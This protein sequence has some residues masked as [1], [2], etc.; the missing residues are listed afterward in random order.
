MCHIWKNYKNW[1][2]ERNIIEDIGVEKSDIS[3]ESSDMSE[4]KDLSKVEELE[5]A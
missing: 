4:S 1:T 5:E 3:D 2:T